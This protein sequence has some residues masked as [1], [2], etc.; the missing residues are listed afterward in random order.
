MTDP[1]P[2]SR[3]ALVVVSVALAVHALAGAPWPRPAAQEPPAA[4][5]PV[6]A[7][8]RESGG[9]TVAVRCDGA[10]GPIRGAAR[11]LFGERLDPNRD[12]ADSLAVLPGL[13]PGRAAA[14]VS[15]RER[16]PFA[17]LDELRR[18]P[19][20][21]TQTLRRLRPWLAV[22]PSVDPYRSGK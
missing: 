13:G 5:C 2:L 1:D 12:D 14:I 20:I 21:G 18:V 3:R 6:P 7:S 9:R 16:A 15:E 4:R 17:S 22:P 11:I 19:G 8:A 10:G